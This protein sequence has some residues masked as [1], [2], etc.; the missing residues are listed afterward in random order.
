MYKNNFSLV[1]DCNCAILKL[2]DHTLIVPPEYETVG[3]EIVNYA[4]NN[5][6]SIA[7]SIKSFMEMGK[8]FPIRK[9]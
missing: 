9:K 7:D 8:Y 6:I 2:Y 1:V 3:M 5:N 4:N